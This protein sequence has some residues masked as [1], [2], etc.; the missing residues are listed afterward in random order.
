MNM[1]WRTKHVKAAHSIRLT[2]MFSLTLYGVYW[3]F[4]TPSAIAFSH[5]WNF[6]E[7]FVSPVL[8]AILLYPLLQRIARVA[9]RENVG[10]LADFLAM[11]Y[12]K[13]RVLGSV[14][15][16]VATLAI[17]FFVAQQLKALSAG[18][19]AIAGTTHSAEM[20]ALGIFFAFLLIVFSV[21]VG[22]RRPTFTHR[23]LSLLNIVAADGILKLI[24]ICLVA[25]PAGILLLH[26]GGHVPT[27]LTPVRLDGGFFM[28]IFLLTGV[29]LCTPHLFHVAVVEPQ[30]E[31]EFEAGRLFLPAYFLVAF[32]AFAVIA[33]AADY[34]PASNPEVGVLE[35]SR[36]LIGRG[37]EV[38][39]FI[40]SLFTAATLVAASTFSIATMVSDQ[41]SL[42]R[43]MQSRRRERSAINVG[44]DI[45]H[46][47]RAVIAIAVIAGC[48]FFWLMRGQESST[49]GLLFTSLMVQLVPAVVA[50]IVWPRAHHRGALAGILFGFLAW[51]FFLA[52]PLLT[53]AGMISWFPFPLAVSPLTDA[54]DERCIASLLLNVGCLLVFSW[55]SKPR[56]IDSIQAAAFID[57]RASMGLS[58]IS[59]QSG[60]NIANLKVLLSQF[61]GDEDAALAMAELEERRG[62]PL[63]DSDVLDTET[64]REAEGILAG[65]IGASLAAS[66]MR[67]QV[68]NPEVQSPQVVH[69]LEQ[70]AQAIR[71]NREML[72][73]T[74][75]NLSQGVVVVDKEF[76]LVAWNDRYEEIFDLGHGVI[77]TGTSL[78]DIIRLNRSRSG[79][80]A[81][82]TEQYIHRR[83]RDVRLGI[84]HV[85][86]R[87]W[88]TGK[89]LQVIGLPMSDGRY[90][91][92]F[93]DLSSVQNVI[94]ELR[95]TNQMLEDRVRR[96]T[97]EL[98]E[99]NEALRRS[100]LLAERA[101]GSQAR[102]LAAASHDLLQP[103]HA[104]RL[105][106]AVLQEQTRSQAETVELARS[107][108]VSIETANRLL[109]ALLNLSRLEV[110]GLRPEVG[111]VEVNQL[112]A[113]LRREFVPL[114]KNRG[115]NLRIISTHYW[116]E[117]DEDLLRSIL[118]N[119]I[120]NAVRYTEEGAVLVTCRRRKGELMFEVR[121]SGP[122]I[123]EDSLDRI[124]EEYFRL[125]HNGEAKSG[126][127]LG[128][129]IV[130][131]ICELLHHRVAVKSRLGGGTT[132]QVAVRQA[133]IEQKIPNAGQ[134]V[135]SSLAGLS[136]LCVEDDETV[137]RSLEFL[138]KRWGTT[139]GFACSVEEALAMEA[140]WDVVLADYHFECGQNGLDLVEK[141]QGR[142][143]AFAL[144]TADSSADV[145]E[146]AAALGVGVIRKPVAPAMMRTF[147]SR[148]LLLKLGR[149]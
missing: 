96:R 104:A 31:E 51:L 17:M 14:V 147:L 10:T 89:T 61:L 83:L 71:L 91:T 76:R 13:D 18:W 122:G 38:V 45:M 48:L 129:S 22:A 140:T 101:R 81:N 95:R 115:L 136:V 133:Q 50:A 58:A 132:F 108:D 59:P 123:A 63:R 56:L 134:S 114:A 49:I 32:L 80:S 119:L 30:A 93:T 146:R 46:I 145:L 90:V 41:F 70:T 142:A 127:G 82:D 100:T 33:R 5:G 25:I 28:T 131:R 24:V 57:H 3:T 126:L 39:V 109:N 44:R 73:A 4:Y 106:L 29:T 36:A 141:M 66:L 105:F 62:R 64:A 102:F 8:A 111:P 43:L 86:E 23:N 60:I 6:V 116:A 72:Q 47:R 9:R 12:G 53:H 143:L 77:Q 112:F 27:R 54:F 92:S 149:N 26:A 55:F 74:L 139:V 1:L 97:A 107:A 40:F 75:N 125:P 148:A 98:T 121:D 21:F 11:R 144:I 88:S 15:T 78:A 65:V 137:R 135:F 138:L 2:Y 117:S 67:W 79:Y 52:R 69:L 94:A 85:F 103:L 87:K 34:F 99:A 19:A 84:P 7:V 124:F 68:A 110:G 113:D 16:F 37:A 35:A 20:S 130:K 42:S 118:Q 120:G 128:L